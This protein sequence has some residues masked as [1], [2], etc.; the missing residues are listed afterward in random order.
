M[1]ANLP[2]Q[3][4]IQ[5]TQAYNDIL[6]TGIFPTSWKEFLTVPI[7]KPGKTGKLPSDYR[8]IVLGNTTR[9][10][11][12]KILNQRLAFY[13]ERNK[14]WPKNQYGFRR[15][16][17]TNYNLIQ[18]VNDIHS[19]WLNNQMLIT[20]L[21]IAKAYDSV[22][23]QIL[24]DVLKELALPNRFITTIIS[25]MQ[26]RI[27]KLHPNYNNINQRI[28]STGIPQGSAL[29]PTLF[30]LYIKEINN[31]RVWYTQISTYADDMIIY[32]RI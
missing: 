27:I 9:K 1:I 8:P 15:G 19:A 29:S 20:S 30:A 31:S 5:L 4:K 24:Q 7:I 18:I 11:F 12:E 22:Q 32:G 2:L 26:N 3:Q 23:L 16:F 17:S 14:L 28:T 25:L 10:I 13:L 21:D 6:H